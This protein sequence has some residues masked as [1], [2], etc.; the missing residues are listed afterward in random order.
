MTT[1]VFI[2][3]SKTFKYH[4]EYMFAGTGSKD[5]IVDFNNCEESNLNATAERM[6][7]SMTADACR[8][9]K[10]DKII[11]YL[12]QETTRHNENNLAEGKFY[13]VFKAKSDW[14]FFAGNGENQFLINDLGKSLTFRVQ[15]EPDNI[16]PKGITEWE[17]LDEIKQIL[18]P[19]QMLWSLIY[20]KLR[21]NRGNTMI[22]LYESDRLIQVI[23]DKNS[24]NVLDSNRKITFNE[25]TQ[26]I[27]YSNVKTTY[28]GL[29]EEINI[30]PRLLF[31]NK[32][33][34]SFEVH[35]QSYI[36]KI[37]GK[38]INTSLDECFFKNDNVKI[39]F[40]GNEMGCGVGMQSIDFVVDLKRNDQ[41]EIWPVELKCKELPNYIV[42]QI[43]R[44]VDW[45]IQYY[46]TNRLCDICPAIICKKSLLNK[47]SF[48]NNLE[49]I[50][51]FNE[52][53]SEKCAPVKLIF[54]EIK[55]NEL[56]F[57]DFKY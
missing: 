36:C 53:Y 5:Y 22:T 17:A 12:Q 24:R 11:F 15:I 56:V 52:E 45:I 39:N 44:Y 40:I 1:H 42:N 7:V 51:K 34:K 26:E 2:V 29:K 33:N 41:V 30:L 31:K 28:K 38:N 35:L 49:K 21:G 10:G 46:K 6:L 37:F 13:G 50:R 54:F 23:R 9:R 18:H 3:N 25:D 16:Y 43:K 4:L 47:K 20:R 55:N 27:E 57:S 14:S 8:I 32:N 19:Y 48:K